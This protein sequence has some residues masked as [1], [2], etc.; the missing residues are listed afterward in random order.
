MRRLRVTIKKNRVD[1]P[2]FL[3]IGLITA[4]E[5]LVLAQVAHV[6]LLE[7][8]SKNYQKICEASCLLI[9]VKFSNAL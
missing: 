7:M 4:K 5:K 2:P 3:Q 1:K 8:K 9:I 6:N